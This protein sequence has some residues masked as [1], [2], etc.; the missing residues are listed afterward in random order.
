MKVGDKVTARIRMLDDLRD[1]GM[2]MQVC[3]D[4]GDIL[5]IRKISEYTKNRFYVSH[6]DVLDRAFI[7]DMNELELAPNEPEV[8]DANRENN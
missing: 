3:A 2:G 4:K 6:V 7:A 1:E 5:I 8:S